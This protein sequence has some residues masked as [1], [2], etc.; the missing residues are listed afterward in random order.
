MEGEWCECWRARTGAQRH[1]RQRCCGSAETAT[2]VPSAASPEM[3]FRASARRRLSDATC[4]PVMV[5][6][7]PML[8]IVELSVCQALVGSRPRSSRLA[9]RG[10]GGLRIRMPR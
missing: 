2:P 1:W 6:R 3:M 5:T 4:F 7:C 10:D 9:V 8:I